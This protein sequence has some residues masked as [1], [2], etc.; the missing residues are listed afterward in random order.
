MPL[1]RVCKRVCAPE[2]VGVDCA[3]GA[4][5]NALRALRTTCPRRR[6]VGVGVATVR[7]WWWN[8]FARLDPKA[9]PLAMPRGSALVRKLSKAGPR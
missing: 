2:G 5:E 3:Q 8:A 4:R 9:W 6:G 7:Q 1:S